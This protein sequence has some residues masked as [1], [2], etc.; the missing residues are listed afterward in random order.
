MTPEEI[1]FI[2]GWKG[3]PDEIYFARL[4]ALGQVPAATDDQRPVAPGGPS[5]EQEADR[6]L[7]TWDVPI[8]LSLVASVPGFP[9]G[10]LPG[11]LREFVEAEAVAVQVPPDMPAM[12]ALGAIAAVAAGRVEV[13]PT[14]GWREGVNLFLIVAMEPGSR[15]SAVH[16]DVMAPVREFERLLVEAARPDV[17]EQATI[18][19]IAEQTLAR[20]EKA[21]AGAKDPDARLALQNDARMAAAALERLEVPSAPRLSTTDATP[22]ALATLLHQNRGRMALISAE[23]GVFGVMAGRYGQG[24]PPNLDVYLAGHAGDPIRVDRRGRPTEFVDHPSLTVCLASQPFVLRQAAQIADLSGRGLLD[25][26]LYSLPADNVGYRQITP[27][28]VASVVRQRFDT[29]IRALAA[30]LENRADPLVL[31]LTID[32]GR[33]LT[34]WRAILEPRRRPDGDL[35][36]VM[37]G[38]SSKLDGA[39]VRIAGLLHLA[40]TV[41]NGANAPIEAS[42]MGAAIEIAGYLITHARAAFDHMGTDRHRDAA[43]RLVAWLQRHGRTE[44]SKRE[45]H[46]ANESLFR[47]AVDLDPALHL[48]EEGGYIRRLESDRRPQ[49]GRPSQRFAVNPHLQNRTQ[50]AVRANQGGF[51]GFA[52]SVARHTLKVPAPHAADHALNEDDPWFRAP[53]PELPDGWPGRTE[54][55]A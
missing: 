41:E 38:W 22:E 42:T 11:W 24:G 55:D 12:F 26:F 23:A 52:G 16:R 51:V 35:G 4:Q 44:F 5:S 18:R 47:H 32:A 28:P 9:T 13:E 8:P 1:A 36:G 43:I 2:R 29:S 7:E 21:A 39:T 49:G 50:P 53:L 27:P 33:L 30:A 6:P 25:Q 34:A 40:A 48:L 54:W 31:H 3:P 17:A 14:E 15:K 37:Q 46:T 45:A 10:A 20:S 19:R